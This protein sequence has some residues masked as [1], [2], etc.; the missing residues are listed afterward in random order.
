M[1]IKAPDIRGF[2]FNTM[3]HKVIDRS[4]LKYGTFEALPLAGIFTMKNDTGVYI[5]LDARTYRSYTDRNQVFTLRKLD[6]Q[7]EIFAPLKRTICFQ[8][9]E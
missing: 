1:S 9:A 4:H 7:I 2:T 3:S 6:T 8:P 5:K